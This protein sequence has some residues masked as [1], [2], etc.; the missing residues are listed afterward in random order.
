MDVLQMFERVSVDF[1]SRKVRML[2]P[3][4]SGL[5]GA[6]RLADANRV[7]PAS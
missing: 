7:R 1:A 6:T 5:G 3:P 4:H 2:A